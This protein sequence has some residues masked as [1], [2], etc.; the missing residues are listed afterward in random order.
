MN[1]VA[2]SLPEICAVL[3]LVLLPTA[4]NAAVTA[5]TNQAAFAAA[6][7]GV[8]VETFE[9]FGLGNVSAIPSLAITSMTGFNDSGASTGQFIGSSTSLPFPMFSSPLP[10]GTRFLSNDLSSPTFGTRSIDFNFSSR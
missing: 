2:S 10:S 1:R 8:V 3:T 9:S 6:A 5:F 7:P 4:A